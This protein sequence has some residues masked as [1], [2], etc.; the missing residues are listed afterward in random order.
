[1]EATGARYRVVVFATAIVWGATTP[2]LTSAQSASERSASERSASGQN[3]SAQNTPAVIGVREAPTGA[4][5]CQFLSDNRLVGSAYNSLFVWDCQ[6]SQR[7][8][9]TYGGRI[10]ALVCSPD[11]RYLVCGRKVF[12]APELK[13]L[14]QLTLAEDDPPI[15]EAAAFSHDGALL[16]FGLNH[17]RIIVVETKTWNV[18]HRLTGPSTKLVG[19]WVAFAETSNRLIACWG[20]HQANL[21]VTS[22]DLSTGATQSLSAATPGK[23]RHIGEPFSSP[24]RRACGD[25]FLAGDSPQFAMS[26]TRKTFALAVRTGDGHGALGVWDAH[27]LLPRWIADLGPG[28]VLGVAFSPDEKFLTIGG[29]STEDRHQQSEIPLRVLS[30]ETG[31]LALSLPRTQETATT[32][33][34]FSPDGKTLALSR[35]NAPIELMSWKSIEEKLR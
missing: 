28:D 12:E 31:E 5:R 9:Y 27:T 23:T 4:R 20:I 34:A 1:M 15:V 17:G 30:A 29:Y 2:P 22:H 25:I 16:A 21:M 6:T 3:I 26:P 10:E 14:R 33:I 32:G 7:T 13:L 8:S 19:I 11:G 18:V 24:V 35:L